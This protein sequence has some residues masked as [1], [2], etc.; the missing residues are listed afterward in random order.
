[1]LLT[2]HPHRKVGVLHK[3]Y[4][5]I[6]FCQ[7]ISLWGEKYPRKEKNLYLSNTNF[8]VWSYHH[9][10]DTMDFADYLKI[11]ITVVLVSIAW[12]LLIYLILF[13]TGRPIPHSSCYSHESQHLLCCIGSTRV[14]YTSGTVWQSIFKFLSDLF[15]C[16]GLK[17][18]WLLVAERL[19]LL[20]F[21][22]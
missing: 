16:Q 20:R 3:C 13:C 14:F 1:M 5:N 11:T 19:N 21:D 10:H 2:M 6:S 17:L 9:H 18:G 7:F 22:A 4:L 8:P 15:Y 12:S